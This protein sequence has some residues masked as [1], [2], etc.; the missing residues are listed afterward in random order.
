MKT[1][2][3]KSTVL[4]LASLAFVG[5][6]AQAQTFVAGDLIIGFR[7]TGN[8]TNYVVNAG[9]VT[10][11]ATTAGLPTGNNFT[12]DMNGGTAGDGGSTLLSGL[13]GNFTT[14]DSSIL[15]SVGGHSTGFGLGFGGKFNNANE[16]WVTRTT[17]VTDT[18]GTQASTAFN[19]LANQSTP[20]STM[21]NMTANFP[22]I[23]TTPGS[24]FNGGS[25]TAA[26]ANSYNTRYG[27]GA[28]QGFGTGYNIQGSVLDNLDLYQLTSG[29]GGQGTYLG[30][31][32]FD[33]GTGSITFTSAI[34]EPSTYALI[35]LGLGGLVALR[36]NKNKQ[37]QA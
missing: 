23:T 20:R 13:T 3:I 25:Q 18:P 16:L 2:I 22:T 35:V 27:S 4:A 7:K 1:N 6:S 19:D 24:G 32:S 31:F 14:I 15:W 37:A 9:A 34:P 30:T 12:I 5:T 10:N 26:N 36:R 17:G 29:E 28:G 11:Y 21:N 33:S 8:S